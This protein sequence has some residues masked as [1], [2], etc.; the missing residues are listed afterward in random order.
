MSFPLHVYAIMTYAKG[1]PLKWRFATVSFYCIQ[2]IQ[3]D[4]PKVAS[5]GIGV[6]ACILVLGLHRYGKTGI[7]VYDGSC[8]EWAA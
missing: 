1:S 6:T 7:P 4:K 3:Q 8:T 5:C 2:G